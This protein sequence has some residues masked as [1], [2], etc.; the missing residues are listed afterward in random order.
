M[1]R[2]GGGNDVKAGLRF[3][4]QDDEERD[5]WSGGLIDALLAR[6]ALA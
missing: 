4:F 1:W 5:Q 3:E 2:E 6:H